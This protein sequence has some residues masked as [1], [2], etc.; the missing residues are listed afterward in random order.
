MPSHDDGTWR[1]VRNIEF[2]S[3][4]V[5]SPSPERINE[6]KMDQDLTD[7]INKATSS[8]GGTSGAAQKTVQ[9]AFS[10]TPSSSKIDKATS[11]LDSFSI[12]VY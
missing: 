3:K 6:F 2:I 9:D 8:Q 10:G 11:D 4:F 7:K 12:V 5:H 1:R